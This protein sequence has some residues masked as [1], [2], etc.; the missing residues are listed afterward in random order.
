MSVYRFP[1]FSETCGA[2][3]YRVRSD[4]D[5]IYSEKTP[6]M[7]NM[8]KR[9]L[10][11]EGILRFPPCFKTLGPLFSTNLCGMIIKE[12]IFPSNIEY[13]Y[14]T[15]LN[16][17]RI[18]K[19]TFEPDCTIIPANIFNNKTAEIKS[20]KLSPSQTIIK[21]EAFAGSK[22]IKEFTFSNINEVQ[23]YAFLDS[24]IERIAITKNFNFTNPGY[25]RG[26]T[27][28]YMPNLKF[29]VLN[30]EP[31]DDFFAI[32]PDNVLLST[33]FPASGHGGSVINKNFKII[34]KEETWYDIPNYE[35]L[36]KFREYFLIYDYSKINSMYSKE[37]ADFINE[38]M[39]HDDIVSSLK[40]GVSFRKLATVKN[41]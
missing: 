31:S 36:D 5:V 11:K 3:R 37:E 15:A 7:I 35:F 13:V 6:D 21:K 16:G 12:L 33:F 41:T 8:A 17:M 38:A 30:L 39:Y 32:K 20:F 10:V 27:L 25:Y 4:N 23:N 2:K 26:F 22:T 18:E 24:S 1:V 9:S 29:I 34:I 14:E 19:V 28:G 40:A